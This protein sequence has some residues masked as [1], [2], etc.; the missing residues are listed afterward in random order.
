MQIEDKEEQIS[1]L[2]GKLV[3]EEKFRRAM[4]SQKRK[5]SNESI[6][7]YEQLTHADIIRLFMIHSVYMQEEYT[8]EIGASIRTAYN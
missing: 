1:E 2:I 3:S 8:R 6:K 5:N 7:L 4:N